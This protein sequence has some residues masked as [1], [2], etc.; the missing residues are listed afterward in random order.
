MEKS[1]SDNWRMNKSPDKAQDLASI[2]DGARVM[3]QSL[4]PN[5]EVVF[6]G[7]ETAQTDKKTILL[8]AAYTDGPAPLPGNQVDCILGLTVHEIGH[9][10][11]SEDRIPFSDRIR[12]MNGVAKHY[13]EDAVALQYL[14]DIY[15][16]MF[17]N[18]VMSG[19]PG[20]KDYLLRQIKNDLGS[21]KP[22]AVLAP[23]KVK[24]SRQDMLNALIAL[25]LVGIEL[26]KDVSQENLNTL[27][28]LLTYGTLM[29]IKKITKETA[30]QEAWKVLKKL[31]VTVDHQED[32][33]FKSPKKES[34]DQSKEQ[35]DDSEQEQDSSNAGASSESGDEGENDTKN[36]GE[37]SSGGGQSSESPEESVD[38]GEDSGDGDS[39]PDSSDNQLD[40]TSGDKPLDNSEQQSAEGKEDDQVPENDDETGESDGGSNAQSEELNDQETTPD[41]SSSPEQGDGEEADQESGD[42]DND[43]GDRETEAEGDNADRSEEDGVGG[44]SGSDESE[45][46]DTAGGQS[47]SE[48]TDEPVDTRPDYNDYKDVNLASH[49][50]DQVNHKEKIDKE[51]G[52]Q[53]QQIIIENS[54]D[55]AELMSHLAKE[56]EAQLLPYIPEEAAERVTLARRS[57]ATEEQKMR[58]VLQQYRLKRTRDYRGLEHGRVSKSRLYRAGYGD[59]H[60]FQRREKPDEIDWAVCLLIDLSGSE[61][62]YR[63]LIEQ[64][65]V[66]I[67]DSLT[68]EKV[69]TVVLGYSWDSTSDGRF[70]YSQH[71]DIPRIYDKEIGKVHL[72]LSNR[73]WGG[74]PSYEGLAAAIAQLI[75]LSPRK[76][77][78]LIHFTDGSPNSGNSNVIPNLLRDARK[79]GIRDIHVGLGNVGYLFK[80]LYGTSNTR[81]VQSIRELPS[82]IETE[83]KRVLG[84]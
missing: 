72:D 4:V 10:L 27:Q 68:K 82:I 20:Y 8:S 28:T 65:V 42:G 54:D 7:I 81:H 15:E 69:E 31:P 12:T 79:K 14:I 67:V 17:V 58:Q 3:A 61:K 63:E 23:L 77:K 18:H 13:R 34:K 48:P 26:P 51:L 74:T 49:L 66:T 30:L 78:L 2:L 6:A 1:L 44:K 19:Y 84:E 37:D 46:G 25:G 70:G 38:N 56:S 83:L 5:V 55:L 57:S 24:C 41:E 22:E 59:T 21:F 50:N 32:G 39:R 60:V 53:I 29:C 73:L 76:K 45:S 64:V 47:K 16:D 35:P 33:I 75:R 9:C 43:S 40:D 62:Q 71:V 11:Y 52:E 80:Q 36:E